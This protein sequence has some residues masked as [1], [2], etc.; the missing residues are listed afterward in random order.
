MFKF[1]KDYIVTIS[2][3]FA[4]ILLGL[5]VLLP[6]I[7]NKDSQCFYYASSTTNKKMS[8]VKFTFF[9]VLD[10]DFFRYNV[11]YFDAEINPKSNEVISIKT[12]KL[13]TLTYTALGKSYSKISCLIPM[14][15]LKL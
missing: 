4:V 13:G 5:Y 6:N 14:E 7:V 3:G 11:M 10:N 1:C 8:Q 15:K 9:K 12:L 2:I